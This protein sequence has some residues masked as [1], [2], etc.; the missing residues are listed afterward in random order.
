MTIATLFVL[1]FAKIVAEKVQDQVVQALERRKQEISPNHN[2][3]VL[4]RV[5]P[6]SYLLL[7]PHHGLVL[8]GLFSFND[9][10]L[11]LVV[12]LYRLR[13]SQTN[14]A[15]KDVDNLVDGGGQYKVQRM[16]EAKLVLTRDQ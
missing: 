15:E 13:D 11:V 2:P 12:E 3:H 16:A 4:H 10:L 5:S 8:K 6:V 7:G 1:N 14:D 9:A